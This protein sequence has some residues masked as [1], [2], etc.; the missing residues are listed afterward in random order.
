MLE[1]AGNTA[2]VVAILAVLALVVLDLV[3]DQEPALYL[4]AVVLG[5]F[6]ASLQLL[7]LVYAHRGPTAT[8]AEAEQP[9]E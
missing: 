8:S 9:L 2:L 6:F 3:P 1:S 5:L 7:F 4:T